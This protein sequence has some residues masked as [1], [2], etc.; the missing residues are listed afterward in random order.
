MN[1]V[2]TTASRYPASLFDD[3]TSAVDAG[4]QSRHGATLA[5]LTT[6]KLHRVP[7]CAVES[8]E[9]DTNGVSSKDVVHRLPVGHHKAAAQRFPS[10][11][12]TSESSMRIRVKT[13]QQ[14]LLNHAQSLRYMCRPYA[15]SSDLSFAA[16]PLGADDE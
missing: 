8:W 15:L 2:S 3:D 16:S 1:L 6:R 11:H 7:G 9:Q 4:R 5:S 14:E 13:E 12:D 10:I